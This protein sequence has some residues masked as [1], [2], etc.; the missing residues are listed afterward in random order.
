MLVIVALVA[1][2][3]PDAASAQSAPSPSPRTTT[4]P[5]PWPAIP[6]C[7]K[8]AGT[9]TP[10]RDD[11]ASPICDVYVRLLDSGA[12]EIELASAAHLNAELGGVL[13]PAFLPGTEAVR[14][15]VTD[16]FNQSFSRT[17]PLVR[18]STN[19]AGARYG[20]WWTT[21]SQVQDAQRNLKDPEELRAELALPS[22]PS[23]IAYS[24][25]IRPGVRAYMGVVAPAFN[26]PG[27]A[28]EFWF[29]PDA[30]VANTVTALSNAVPCAGAP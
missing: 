4:P 24:T 7:L 20:S 21:R 13:Y 3:V 15:V 5:W 26:E 10:G 9:A 2:V 18:V 30:V 8:D 29:P 1:L 12:T 11:F 27:G 6:S 16:R 17:V 25:A 19:A 14:F 23:C 22:T 28:V